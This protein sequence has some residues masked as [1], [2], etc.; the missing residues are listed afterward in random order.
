MK[1]TLRAV[2]FAALMLVGTFGLRNLVVTST[3]GHAVQAV[4]V[5]ADGSG[6]PLPGSG[7]TAIQ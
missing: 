6:N 1:N 3:S 2:T 4:A 7:R 5:L